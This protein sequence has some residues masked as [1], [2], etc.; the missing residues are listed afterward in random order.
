VRGRRRHL[1]PIDEAASVG[2]IALKAGLTRGRRYTGD[3]LVDMIVAWFPGEDLGEWDR[4]AITKVGVHVA[5]PG[6]RSLADVDPAI[7]ER[8]R[9]RLAE[10]LAN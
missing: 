5:Q 10:V 3:E 6:L 4:Q 8:V 7:T 1:E 2:N 9:K